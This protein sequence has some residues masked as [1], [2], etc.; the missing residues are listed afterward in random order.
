MQ[1]PRLCILMELICANDLMT[2]EHDLFNITHDGVCFL[3]IHWCITDL[4]TLCI[5]HLDKPIEI[6]HQAS[7]KKVWFMSDNVNHGTH[8][9]SW[10]RGDSAIY[11][12]STCPVSPFESFEIT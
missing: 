7:D 6:K 5:A 3:E 1:V 8:G 12:T 11:W 10:L 2:N 4:Q 9:T